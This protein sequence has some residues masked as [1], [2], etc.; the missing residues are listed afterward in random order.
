MYSHGLPSWWH[1]RR[2]ILAPRKF[3]STVLLW[4]GER[5]WEY[6]DLCRLPGRKQSLVPLDSLEGSGEIGLVH[7][8]GVGTVH[9]RT[10]HL[11][12][13]R[14]WVTPISFMVCGEV[15]LFFR[16]S[17]ILREERKLKT[18]LPLPQKTCLAQSAYIKVSSNLKGWPAHCGWGNSVR[19]RCPAGD[20]LWLCIALSQAWR[21]RALGPQAELMEGW[22]LQANR[23]QTGAWDS[24]L[25]FRKGRKKQPDLDMIAVTF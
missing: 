10:Q 18:P 1:R 15:G 25:T 17:T 20:P 21:S 14:E 19:K 3:C 5:G 12:T 16:E 2:T 22:W 9:D 7:E 4:S 8:G 11:K 6:W 23:A 13:I 24:S